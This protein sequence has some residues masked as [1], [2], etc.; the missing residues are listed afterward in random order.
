MKSLTKFSSL[1]VLL[2]AIVLV[3]SGCAH[4]EKGIAKAASPASAVVKPAEVTTTAPAPPVAGNTAIDQAAL[5]RLKQM[6]DTLTAAKSFTYHSRSFLELQAPETGQLLTFVNH[7]ELALQ[8]PNKLR[9]NVEGDVRTLQLYFDGEKV[10]AIDVDKN[11]YAVS[12]TLTTID[13]M[14]AYVLGKARIGLPAADF[15]NSNPYAVMSK[16]VS[17]AAH[18]GESVVNGVVCDHYA[19]MEPN[20]DWEIW[21]QKGDNALPLRLAMTYKQTKDS[22]HF[23]IEFFDWQ[24][25]PKLDAKTFVFNKPKGAIQAEFGYY[26]TEAAKK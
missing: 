24:L 2:S 7:A 23:L 14:I 20:V 17:Y 21:I 10:S 19:Y 16:E 25:N 1:P 4:E 12:P 9:V 22:P 26:Q 11:I 3:L 5:A 18:I 13:D 15:L 8:R 6:S